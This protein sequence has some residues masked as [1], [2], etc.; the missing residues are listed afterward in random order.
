MKKILALFLVMSLVLGNVSFATTVTPKPA[1]TAPTVTAAPVKSPVNFKINEGQDAKSDFAKEFLHNAKNFE[2]YVFELTEKDFA[3]SKWQKYVTAV[4]AQAT[5]INYYVSTLYADG[6]LKQVIMLSTE[7]V[8][9]AIDEAAKSNEAIRQESIDKPDASFTGFYAKVNQAP[10]LLID[11]KE[12]VTY[13]FLSKNDVRNNY[14]DLI[15][16]LTNTFKLYQK[17]SFYILMT[18][19]YP[20]GTWSSIVSSSTAELDTALGKMIAKNNELLIGAKLMEAPKPVEVKPVVVEKS[21]VAAKVYYVLL[22]NKDKTYTVKEFKTVAEAKKFQT[23]NIK[24]YGK[25]N[26][27]YFD[28]KKSLDAATAKLKKKK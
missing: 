25:A 7:E 1:T 9:A 12:L 11:E 19:T 18:T 5:D 3:T 13:Q 10:W 23:A 2:P 24:K 26:V 20:S 17:G 27:L 8:Q 16:K 4:Y 21:A 15:D 28:L 22:I 14:P 6:S